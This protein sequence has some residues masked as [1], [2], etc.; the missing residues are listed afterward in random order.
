ML[1]AGVRR[2]AL[3]GP[4][5]IHSRRPYMCR[6]LLGS[7]SLTECHWNV[8]CAKSGLAGSVERTCRWGLGQSYVWPV[9]LAC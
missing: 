1:Q 2:S 5:L 4:L 6:S 8:Y 9:P 3:M 7:G